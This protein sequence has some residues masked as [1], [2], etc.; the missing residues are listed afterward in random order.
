[1][2]FRSIGTTA[3]TLFGLVSGTLSAQSVSGLHESMSVKTIAQTD[4][5]DGQVR[6]RLELGLRDQVVAWVEITP[7]GSTPLAPAPV[8]ADQSHCEWVVVSAR[9]GTASRIVAIC[10]LRDRDLLVGRM[11]IDEQGVERYVPSTPFAET[12]HAAAINAF[13]GTV[14]SYA[15]TVAAAGEE[16]GSPLTVRVTFPD[17]VLGADEELRGTPSIR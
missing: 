16:A 8:I 13:R 12:R 14:R 7:R 10:E 11:S 1:M 4:I 15:L 9:P 6:T 2:R 17:G 5:G 3:L